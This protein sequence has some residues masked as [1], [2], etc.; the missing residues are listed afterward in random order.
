MHAS[1]RLPP[2]ACH[3][4][5]ARLA[6]PARPRPRPDG[7]ALPPPPHLHPFQSPPATCHR[8]PP[9]PRLRPPAPS[10][11]KSP[12]RPNP[13]RRRRRRR[14]ATSSAR[15]TG[16]AGINKRRTSPVSTSSSSG[17]VLPQRVTRKRRS[18]RRGP[19]SAARRPSSA[20]RPVS[21]SEFTGSC[22]LLRFVCAV[23]DAMVGRRG[24]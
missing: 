7:G 8:A 12:A 5:P 22:V 24:A 6:A 2:G 3:L 17:D 1:P 21:A 11:Y 15:S 10:G 23:R 20:P 4:A 16:M 18:A 19:R 9:P 13:R 14:A